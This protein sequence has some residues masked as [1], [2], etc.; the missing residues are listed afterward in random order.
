[1]AARPVLDAALRTFPIT[2]LLAVPLM[3]RLPQLFAWMQAPG[4]AGEGRAW[5]LSV[6]FFAV[7]GFACFVIW[8][9][10]ARLLH[11]EWQPQGSARAQAPRATAALGFVLYALTAT[12]SA[13]DW[14][15]SLTPE[16]H[17]TVFGLL[18]GVGQVMS[19]L[20]LAIIV[21]A[22]LALRAD[23]ARAGRFHDLG[24]LMLALVLLWAY[25]AFMQFL[26]MWI[27]DLPSDIG[28]YLPR[29][30]T[31][32]SA[33]GLFLAATHFV[34]PFLILLSREVKRRPGLLA[35]VA[36]LMMLACLADAYWLVLPTFRPQGFEMQWSDLFALLAVGGIWLGSLMRA[37]Q[38][39]AAVPQRGG[40]QEGIARHA[41]QHA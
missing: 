9:A 39:P 28:W 38:A 19:A 23:P 34:L 22:R 21:G 30:Q 20:S 40:P 2:V 5:Y 7:R 35:A 8:L 6:P 13:V 29:T 16:W 1:V 3:F 24:K 32:W 14:I 12:F 26:I 41:G 18:I 4:G 25:L 17:S 36:G 15:M 10:L 11:R 27:E 37:I 33:L 31:S